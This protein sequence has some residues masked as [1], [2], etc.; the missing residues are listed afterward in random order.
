MEL[1]CHFGNIKR[2]IDTFELFRLIVVDVFISLVF[3]ISHENSALYF[4]VVVS[5]LEKQEP[6]TTAYS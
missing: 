4:E 5:D 1:R 3:S 6:G 2:V